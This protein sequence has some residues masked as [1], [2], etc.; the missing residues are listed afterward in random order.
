M[1][2]S[3]VPKMTPYFFSHSYI[4][5]L[6]KSFIEESAFSKGVKRHVHLTNPIIH[7]SLHASQTLGGT[8]H[9]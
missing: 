3:S 8:M 2:E 1:T 7:L 6:G 9:H 5:F 4:V